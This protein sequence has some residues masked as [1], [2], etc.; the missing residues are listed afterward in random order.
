VSAPHAIAGEIRLYDRLLMVENAAD[1]PRDFKEL[2]NPDSL[3][4]VKNAWLEPSLADVTPNDHFQ[5]IRL[6]YFTP[7]SDTRPGQP[8]FNRTVTLKDAWAKIAGKN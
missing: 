1:D 7:D 4:V 8:V 6:G 5:F 3:K 2:L